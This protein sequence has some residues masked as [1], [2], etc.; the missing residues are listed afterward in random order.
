MTSYL[1][2]R[3]NKESGPYTFQDLVSF[4]LKPY[5]LVWVQGKSA[6]WRYPSEIEEL[7]PYAPGVEEQPFDRFFKKP[8]EEEHFVFQQKQEPVKKETPVKETVVPEP[9]PSATTFI[10]EKYE[11]YI[12]KKSVFVTLPGQKTVAVQQPVQPKVQEPV[13]PV[14][15]QPEPVAD[16]VIKVTENPEAKIKY[17]QP[18]DE[19]KEMYV[20]TLQDRKSKIAR[21]SFLVTNLKRASVIV[22][23]VALGVLAGFIIKSDGGDKTQPL[24][25]TIATLG[26][27]PA[28]TDKLTVEEDKPVEENTANNNSLT[29]LNNGIVTPGEQEE[30]HKPLPPAVE[31]RLLELERNQLQQRQPVQ[32]RRDP[33]QTE[34]QNQ[35][36]SDLPSLESN[37]QTGERNR[38]VREAGSEQKAIM[39]PPTAKKKSG[40]E[41]FVSVTSNDYKRVAFGGIRNLELTVK[42][43]SRFVLD[44]VIVELQY[45]KPSE[46]PLKTELVQFHTISPNGSLTMRI[47]D[48]NRGIKVSYKIID[49][50]SAQTETAMSGF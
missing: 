37:P 40:L 42:N 22:G 23:L 49:I 21:K 12:P 5:D 7:K 41:S 29:E 45:L 30:E 4:G 14:Q 27:Q 2:L 13:K 47:R 16:P 3:S 44:K 33:A 18:L 24:A 35:E 25:G 32:P 28:T 38:K 19:I 26:Q 20:K 17:S 15:Y 11:K 6:A 48:T 8:K 36:T 39:P 10:E 50:Q 34:V 46:E 31:R 9:S 43:D 1:L